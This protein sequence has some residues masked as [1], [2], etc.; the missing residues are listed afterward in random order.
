MSTRMI[1]YSA[2]KQFHLLPVFPKT[3]I[4]NSLNI[5]DMIKCQAVCSSI[6]LLQDV[7]LSC[8]GALVCGLKSKWRDEEEWKQYVSNKILRHISF[9]Q[10][11]HCWTTKSNPLGG[12]MERILGYIAKRCREGSGGSIGGA[13]KGDIIGTYMWQNIVWWMWL[14]LPSVSKSVFSIKWYCAGYVWA[15]HIALWHLHHPMNINQWT[16]CRFEA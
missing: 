4:T 13:V 6:F 15:P 9:M 7:H 5:S 12:I 10:C 8:H 3:R 1:N 16:R 14:Y 11:D 2:S